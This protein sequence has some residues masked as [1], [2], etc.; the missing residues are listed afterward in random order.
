VWGRGAT[1]MPARKT[2]RRYYAND[3]THS[4][5]HRSADFEDGKMRLLCQECLKYYELLFDT[6]AKDHFVCA[7]CYRR[8]TNNRDWKSWGVGY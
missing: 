6:R 5:S 1:I 2:A 8:L 3:H 7:G 4:I